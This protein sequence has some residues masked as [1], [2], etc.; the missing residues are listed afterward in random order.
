[1]VLMYYQKQTG[2]P[3]AF[4]AAFTMDF[5]HADCFS[6]DQPTMVPA[7]TLLSQ[8][9]WDKTQN[10]DTWGPGYAPEG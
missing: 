7:K 6:T 3:H 4:Q 9:A 8:L 2:A 10:A 5:V 1:M